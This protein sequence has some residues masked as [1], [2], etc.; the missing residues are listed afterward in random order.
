[1]SHSPLHRTMMRSVLDRRSAA[2]ADYEI[3]VET[4]CQ[5]EHGLPPPPASPPFF[6]ADGWA[7]CRKAHDA[8][9]A[10]DEAR[11]ESRRLFVK[12]FNQET[13]AVRARPK[14]ARY[15]ALRAMFKTVLPSRDAAVKLAVARSG[16]LEWRPRAVADCL[17][18]EDDY[19]LEERL[20]RGRVAVGDRGVIAWRALHLYV[21]PRFVPKPHFYHERRRLA[22][23]SAEFADFVAAQAAA[24]PETRIAIPR[25][26]D[27]TSDGGLRSDADSDDDDEEEVVLTRTS[28]GLTATKRKRGGATSSSRKKARTENK[29]NNSAKGQK[30]KQKKK[31][32]KPTARKP[33]RFTKTFDSAVHDRAQL[34][35]QTRNRFTLMQQRVPRA[36]VPGFETV[37]ARRALK[38]QR[39]AASSL[40]PPSTSNPRSTSEETEAE[41]EKKTTLLHGIALPVRLTE[42]SPETG[43][44]EERPREPTEEEARAYRA[45]RRGRR[46][47]AF[48]AERDAYMRARVLKERVPDRELVRAAQRLVGFWAQRQRKA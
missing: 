33:P 34:L 24:P 43:E 5:D 12:A 37:A 8:K 16:F 9:K 29:K 19:S 26:E 35:A 4:P 42:A 21:S 1:M 40:P 11:D 22:A 47:R 45:W 28:R 10:R 44:E 30:Q 36:E 3:A 7:E 23:K 2:L 6:D 14:S 25:P 41:K 15:L 13:R 46:A 38:Q 27:D 17:R 20:P 48:F 31:T 18:G 39:L 32:K